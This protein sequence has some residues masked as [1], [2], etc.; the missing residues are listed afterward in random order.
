M[1]YLRFTG[2]RERGTLQLVLAVNL[3][4]ADTK[5]AGQDK[6]LAWVHVE[7]EKRYG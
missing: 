2:Y 6:Q 5:G 4:V 3:H 7:L 1:F